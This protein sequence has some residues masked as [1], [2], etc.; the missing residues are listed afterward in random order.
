MGLGIVERVRLQASCVAVRVR[1]LRGNPCQESRSGKER[2]AACKGKSCVGRS[3]SML[4]QVNG[5]GWLHTKGKGNLTRWDPGVVNRGDRRVE[6]MWDD[7]HNV[8]PSVYQENSG[9]GGMPLSRFK[10]SLR[11]RERDGWWCPCNPKG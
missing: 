4:G 11:E 6:R 5:R 10:K 8:R 1:K 2:R 9:V 7:G 3:A